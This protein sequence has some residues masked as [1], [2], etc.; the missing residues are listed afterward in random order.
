MT[1]HRK[2][3]RQAIRR[4]F[5]LMEILIVVAIIVI[6]AGVG[7]VALFPQLYKAKENEARMKAQQIATAIG[8]YTTDHD[9]TPPQSLQVLLTNDGI[10]GPYLKTSDAIVDPW[11]NPYQLDP[12]GSRFHNGSGDPDV[13]TT[14]P[15]GKIVGNFKGYGN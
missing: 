10:G 12:T 2:V 11:G 13:F 9:G 7:T 15:K 8:A 1:L 14:T 5:T 6:L 4:A 3:T